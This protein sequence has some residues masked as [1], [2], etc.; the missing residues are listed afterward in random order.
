[1]D[2]LENEPITKEVN[3]VQFSIMS[4]EEIRGQS[5][6]E[7][8]KHDTYDKDIPVIKGLFDPR[9][10]TTD[11]GKVCNTCGLTNKDCPG[12]FGHIELAKPFYSYQFIDITVKVLN[13]VC[14][15]CS[16]LLIDKDNPILET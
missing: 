9:M 13:C 2:Y 8:V 15:K 3:G 16:K 12:H 1:M 6:V 14:F 11:M 7:V 10:G 5:V 4:P